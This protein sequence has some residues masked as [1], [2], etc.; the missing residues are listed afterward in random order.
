MNRQMK[1]TL[2]VPIRINNFKAI[3]RL[4]VAK[5]QNKKNKKKMYTATG[6]GLGRGH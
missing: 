4:M 1:S 3:P 2:Q 5:L 6:R